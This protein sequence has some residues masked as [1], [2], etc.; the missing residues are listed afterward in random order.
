MTSSVE[1]TRGPLSAEAKAGLATLRLG[2]D[3]VIWLRNLV[4]SLA[5]RHSVLSSNSL[6]SRRHTR[7]EFIYTGLR[8]HA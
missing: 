8:N 4:F 5:Q 2:A 1:A 7:M 3:S 6:V